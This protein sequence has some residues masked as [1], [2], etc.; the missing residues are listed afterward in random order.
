LSLWLL[1][2]L[3]VVGKHVQNFL[4]FYFERHLQLEPVLLLVEK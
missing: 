4:S 2:A 1:V 3:L